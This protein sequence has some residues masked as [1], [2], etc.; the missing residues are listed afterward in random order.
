M[1]EEDDQLV[2]MFMPAL[3][4]LLYKAEKDKGGA[5]SEKEVLDIR[6]NAICMTVKLSVAKEMEEKRGYPDI[7]AEEAWSEW[8]LARKDIFEIE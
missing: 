7:I 4:T 8:Q 3:V 1:N 2:L 6:D 5:L